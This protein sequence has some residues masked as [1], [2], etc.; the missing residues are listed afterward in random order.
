MST[1]K[2]R[3]FCFI[4]HGGAG[5]TI[6]T[7]TILTNVGLIANPGSIEKGS[8][9]SDFTPEE[10]SHK[11]SISNAYFSFNRGEYQ[12]NLIDTPGFADFR[13]EVAGALR[14]V[15]SAVLLIDGTAGIQVNTNYVWS[16]AEKNKL[17]RFVFV[18]KMDLEGADF[19]KV[20]DE[21]QNTFRGKFVPITAPD[22]S[23]EN[24]KGV[25][26]LLQEVAYQLEGNQEKK[27]TDVDLSEFEDYKHDLLESLVELDEALMEKYFG[28]EEITVEE[29]IEALMTGVASGEIIPVFAGSALKNSGVNLLLDYLVKLIPAPDHA[30]V[31]TGTWDGETVEVEIKEGD[32]AVALVGKTMVDPY[33]GKLSIFKV[34]T[35]T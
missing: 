8:T 28:D 15:E 4:S 3:N 29:L 34:L 1:K 17:P 13:G 6:L 9:A 10:K 19:F 11:H 12:I 18:N 30:G 33:V 22:G 35:G 26:D 27:V 32:T 16:M 2:I 5:K 23:G 24:Y 7:E 20:L 14:M 25:F 21:I 31:V